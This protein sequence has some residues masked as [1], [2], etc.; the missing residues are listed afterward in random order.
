M[1]VFP[2]LH[3]SLPRITWMKPSKSE[4]VPLQTGPHPRY[5]KR[6]ARKFSGED[7]SGEARRRIVAKLLSGLASTAPRRRL[8]KTSRYQHLRRPRQRAHRFLVSSRCPKR[9]RGSLLAYR[10]IRTK[11]SESKAG[12]PQMEPHLGYSLPTVKEY[13][14]EHNSGGGAVPNCRRA[15]LRP[16]EHTL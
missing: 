7:E 12:C 5:R 9:N 8:F 14:D 3:R 16:S 11:P 1:P 13:P 6:T 15:R 2:F 10:R 4:A